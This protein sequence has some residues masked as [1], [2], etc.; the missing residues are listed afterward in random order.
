MGIIRHFEFSLSAV[1]LLSLVSCTVYLLRAGN[2]GNSDKARIAYV[3][4][5]GGALQLT[6]SDWLDLRDK[7]LI[8]TV[9][10]W[11]MHSAEISRLL[12][13]TQP[14]GSKR[15]RKGRRSNRGNGAGPGRNRHKIRFSGIEQ[16]QAIN[17]AYFGD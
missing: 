15:M 1:C 2:K 6:F 16:G 9:I 8:D 10:T 5:D 7:A 13:H 14:Y 11:V 3:M 12:M 17:T 4:T